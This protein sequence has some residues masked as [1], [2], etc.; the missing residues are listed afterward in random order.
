MSRTVAFVE[1]QRIE[2]TDWYCKTKKDRCPHIIGNSKRKWYCNLFYEWLENSQRPRRCDD[3]RDSE[4]LYKAIE[5]IYILVAEG[6]H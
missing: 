1:T 2:A 6:T 3:C 4:F 5:P